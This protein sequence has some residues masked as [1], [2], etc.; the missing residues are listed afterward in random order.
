MTVNGIIAEYNPFHNGHAY[1]ISKSK[2]L[3]GA[4]F[5]IIVM[6]GDFVQRGAPAILDKHLRT[7]MALEGGAD[8]VIEL[9][10]VYALSCAEQFAFG[11]VSILNSLGVTDYLCFGSETDDL[12]QLQTLSNALSEESDETCDAIKSSLQ[13]G[14]SYPKARINALFKSHPEYKE[15]TEILSSPNNILALEYLQALKKLKST[16][17][18][19]PIS[20]IGD[21][22]HSTESTSVYS[23]ATAIRKLLLTSD[24]LDPLKDLLPDLSFRIIVKQAKEN[25]LL[26]ENDF[27]SLLLYKLLLQSEKGY[28]SFQDINTDL[29]DRIRKH[30]F[31]FDSFKGFCDT[32][33]PKT[34]PM[35]A[36]DA[37]YA[38]SF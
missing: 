18:P 27:S 28:D 8:L 17:Q 19:F 22:Y 15:F 5:T 6:S 25:A 30:L 37:D 35:P 1:H 11:G 10:T 32:L 4:D 2:D 24:Q 36:S 21:A 20:R 3:T 13:N 29:S 23:S 26:T 12:V 31:E 34:L 33:K 16:I 7:H 14:H 9:P 38:I